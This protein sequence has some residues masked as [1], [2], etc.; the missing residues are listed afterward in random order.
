M[1]LRQGL[2]RYKKKL[3]DF[4]VQ[5]NFTFVS[6]NVDIPVDR[7]PQLTSRNRP[8]VGQARFIYNV[9]GEWAKP[10][11]RSSARFYANSVSRR[12][13][14][15]GTFRLPDIYQEKNVFLDFVYQY[16]I[17]ENGKWTMRFSAENLSDN[18]YR[19]TQA[20]FLVR[21]FRIGRTFSIGTSYSFF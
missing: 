7:F 1:E 9:I 17:K 6:S 18:Q 15:I 16:D 12:I 5:T 14:D 2:G 8:L 10:K 11:L 13:T 21:A 19:N 4:A 20:D 3:R